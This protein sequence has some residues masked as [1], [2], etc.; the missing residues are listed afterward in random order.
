[1]Y[2]DIPLLGICACAS[3]MGK[4]TL[5][6]RLLP[7]LAAQGLRVSVIK[8]THAQFDLDR[9][10]K[11]SYR[12]RE[13]GAAQVLLSAPARWALLTETPPRMD[14]GRL[15]DMLRHLDLTLADLVLVEGFRTAPIPKIEV[16]RSNCD[17]QPLALQDGNVIAVAG[18]A[19]PAIA[20]PWFPLDDIPGVAR[21]VQQWLARQQERR[22]QVAAG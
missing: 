15:L 13:A 20:Q 11:D 4:T 19:R 1:M 16:Y 10:G 14:D 8:Q 7:Q 17:R 18:D 9:P 5:L 3:G 2:F 21:H 6:T 12:M 22:L